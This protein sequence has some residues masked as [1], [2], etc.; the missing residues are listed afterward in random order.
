M[1]KSLSFIRSFKQSSAHYN[2]LASFVCATP[3]KAEPIVF[4]HN[5]SK[6]VKEEK[7]IDYNVMSNDQILSHL[8]TKVLAQHKLEEVLCDKTRSVY[9]RRLYFAKRI[10]ETQSK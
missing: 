4:E 1:Q 2:T 3:I 5:L 7:T 10:L 8:N 6:K 9:L